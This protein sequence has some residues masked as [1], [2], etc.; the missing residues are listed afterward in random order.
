VVLSLQYSLAN[1][2]DEPANEAEVEPLA[3]PT[4]KKHHVWAMNSADCAFQ[5]DVSSYSGLTYGKL[6][7][8]PT[9]EVARIYSITP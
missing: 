2:S 4:V 1:M 9:A 7:T 6:L 5:T 8:L 3:K